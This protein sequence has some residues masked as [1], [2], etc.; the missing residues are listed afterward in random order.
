MEMKIK[1]MAFMASITVS[2]IGLCLVGQLHASTIFEIKITNLSPNVLTPA[3]FITHNASFD[4][5][6][7]GYAASPEVELLAEEGNTTGVR[8]LAMDGITAGSVMDY[9]EAFDGGPIFPGAF[10]TINIEADMSHPLLSYLSMLAVSN[11]AFIGR[12]TG[13]G[14]IYLF[15]GGRHVSRR[16]WVYARNV[17]DAGTEDND[18]L[19]VNVPGL[20]GSGSISEGSVVTRPHPGIL[21]TGEIDTDFNWAISGDTLVAKIE[22]SPIPEPTTIVLLG[23][24]LLGLAGVIRKKIS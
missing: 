3:P 19:A 11:D 12:T 18:E 21:G 13:D 4:L 16:Y 20:G 7:E 8:D 10:A 9:Q 24:G 5:F 23:I 6:T 17:W 15:F 14:A 2:I 22:I 1:T